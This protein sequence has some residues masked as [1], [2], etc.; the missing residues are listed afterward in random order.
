[1]L[2]E[3]ESSQKVRALFAATQSRV[4]KF[5]ENTG[6]WEVLGTG[7]GGGAGVDCSGPRFQSDYIGD[8][9]F[10]T[11]GVDDPMYHIIEQA[12]NQDG[13]MLSKIPD[14]SL[15]GLTTARKLWVWNNVVFLA[16]VVMDGAKK[17]YRIVWSDYNAPTSF[18]S[19]LIGSITGFFDLEFG[20]TILGGKQSSNGF[21]IYTNQRMWLMSVN[22]STASNSSPFVFQKLPGIETGVCLFYENTL[23]DVGDGQIYAGRDRIYFYNQFIG[24]PEPLEWLHLADAAVYD[25]VRKDVCGAHV[26]VYHNKGDSN[27]VY[28]SFL[29][30]D[31]KNGC[32]D[33]T[34]RINRTYKTVDIVDAGFTAFC[35]HRPQSVPTIRDLLISQNVCSLYELYSQ[36]IGW[37]YEG[38]PN[39]LPTPGDGP[40]PD[41]IFNPHPLYQALNLYT[42]ISFYSEDYTGDP[43]ADSLCTILDGQPALTDCTG[44][45][46]DFILIGANS[47][48]WC[49][50]QI[51]PTF[52]RERCTNPTAVGNV[53][54]YGYE[55]SI[56]TYIL[57]GYDS[58][59]RFAPAFAPEMLV[60]AVKFGLNYLAAPD[61]NSTIKFRI[62]ISGQVADPNVETS[63]VIKWFALSDKKLKCLNEFLTQRDYEKKNAVPSTPLEWNFMYAG[64]FVYFELKITGTGGDALFGGVS[65]QVKGIGMRNF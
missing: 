59:L 39:P 9:V 25:K 12:P 1:M 21:V 33:I 14:L 42:G 55:T 64:R 53:I 10:F 61:T 19:S 63:C 58:I 24:L 18:D 48:D 40:T 8:Y 65:A 56:G 57:D 5:H 51:G 13:S 44:C 50:K 41:S 6:N 2:A 36:G 16:D 32:P 47:V 28:M 7:F 62:G 20:E 45:D 23:V 37:M 26:S 31:S 15:I 49:L 29:T 34:L 35:T 60:E 43:S 52:Y 17:S 4:L 54:F 22:Q 38:L 11:N 30:T 27:E 46:P 3:A